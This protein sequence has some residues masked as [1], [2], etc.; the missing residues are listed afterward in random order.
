MPKKKKQEKLEKPEKPKKSETKK[1]KKIKFPAA[2]IKKI[3]QKDERIGKIS[4]F[5]PIVLGKATELFLI[6]FVKSAIKNH[7]LDFDDMGNLVESGG[8][9]GFLKRVE[10]DE[11]C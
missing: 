4:N 5:A 9:F 10:K 7:K 2:R 11:D 3:M 6:D 1:P 8:R